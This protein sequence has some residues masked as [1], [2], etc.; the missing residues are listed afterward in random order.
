LKRKPHKSKEIQ[1]LSAPSKKQLLLK[2]K[3]EEGGKK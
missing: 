2:Q 1:E 3:K